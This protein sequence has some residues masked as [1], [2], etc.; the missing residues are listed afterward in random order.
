MASERAAEGEGK[1]RKR[2]RKQPVQEREL[3]G[4]KYLRRLRKLLEPLQA[5]ATERD[6]VGNRRLFYDQYGA[7]PLFCLFNPVVDSLRR[8]RQS[9]EKSPRLQTRTVGW[10]FLPVAEGAQK[11]GAA[12]GGGR[13][14]CGLALRAY[15]KTFWS[16]RNGDPSR[17]IRGQS[18]KRWPS[19]K[20]RDRHGRQQLFRSVPDA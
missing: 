3:R 10:A 20:E 13:S 5:A 9:T 12:S 14:V 19:C 7:L 16:C 2:Q 17:M 11:R 1:G 18:P 4:F 6:C 15:P 8:L